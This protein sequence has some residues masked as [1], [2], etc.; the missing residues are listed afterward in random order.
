MSRYAHLAYT[1]N[2][3]EVQREMGSAVAAGRRL[4]GP[5]DRRDPLTS[6]EA[7]FITSLDGFLLGTVGET[8]WPYIQFR[9]GP[10][11]FLHVLDERTVG[12]ADAGGNRQY[13]TTGNLRGDGR[14]ALFLL[15]HARSSRLKM[16]GHATVTSAEQ[17]P[18]LAER[19]MTPRTEGRVERLVTIAVEGWDWN[20]HKHITPRYSARE[21]TEA[22]APTYARL[23]R[24]E[25]LEQENAALRAELRAL[26]EEP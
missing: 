13:I 1:P 20:C 18:E 26:R 21:L 24:L 14:V 16:Y 4:G 3:R 7:E 9:G 8:G 6:V 12:F 17:A 19:L 2:V 5:A 11:G 23:E 25:A 10:P 15:D 22:L